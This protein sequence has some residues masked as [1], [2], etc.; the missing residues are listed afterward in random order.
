MAYMKDSTGRRLD[1]FPVLGAKRGHT[2]P[3][4]G[5][6]TLESTLREGR[7]SVALAVQGDSTGK[8]ADKKRWPEH[9][10]DW[11][12]SE[13]TNYAVQI[14][15]WNTGKFDPPVVL[16]GNP[17]ARYGAFTATGSSV[18]HGGDGTAMNGD[19]DIRIK[20]SF[21]AWPIA[22]SANNTLVARWGGTAGQNSFFLYAGTDGRILFQ[23]SADGLNTVSVLNSSILTITPNTPIWLRVKVIVA[24]GAVAFYTSTDGTN[25][26]VTGAPA[27]VGAMTIFDPGSARGYDVGG[28]SGGAAGRIIANIYEVEI[29]KGDGGPS[30]VPRYIDCWHARNFAVGTEPVLSGKPVLTVVN[31]SWPGAA[32][33][34][35]SD[36]V[37]LPKMIP[38]DYNTAATILSCSHNDGIKNGGPYM[39]EWTNWLNAL[40]TRNPVMD[41]VVT[42]QNPKVYGAAAY[43]DAHATRRHEI[44]RWAINNRLTIIDAYQA[45]LDSPAGLA[46]LVNADGIHPED[47]AATD[48]TK[49]SPLWAHVVKQAILGNAS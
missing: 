6:K 28:H 2:L 9:V 47:G 22:S 23:W 12:A 16:S 32:I 7:K 11:M 27:A 25:W 13:Y 5:F 8:T 24:T 3:A 31:G 36:P 26:T 43:V 21:P 17:S 48:L 29:R 1:S 37:N 38:F 19:F 42:T 35:L 40:R 30:V 46:S 10:A 33:T 14:V 34:H 44:M 15:N 41:V 20:A 49:G 45:F 4:D 39:A 18:V